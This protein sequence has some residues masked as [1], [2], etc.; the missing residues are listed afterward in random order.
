MAG[1]AEDEPAEDVDDV[2][3]TGGT[4]GPGAGGGEPAPNVPPGPSDVGMVLPPCQPGFERTSA[5]GRDCTYLLGSTCYEDER[6]A[7]ACACRGLANSA[8]IIDGF[9]DP[10][11]PQ[12]VSCAAR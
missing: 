4:G 9:L 7:C 6:V 3:G 12:Q 8:C 1:G 10:N 11:A 5:G 2:E